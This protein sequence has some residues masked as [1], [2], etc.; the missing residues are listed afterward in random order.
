MAEYVL[1]EMVEK[2]GIAQEFEIASAATSTEE[3][4]MPAYPPAKKKL[5]E[6]GISCEGH[7]AHRMTADEYDYY[8]MVICMDNNNIRSL[9]RRLGEDTDGKYSLM[10]D[11]TDR[12]GYEVADPWYTGNF[13]A[14]WRDVTDG[15][16]GLLKHLGYDE[17]NKQMD[18][19]AFCKDAVFCI[20]KPHVRRGVP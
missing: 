12:A 7:R 15:C 5:A 2:R 18:K 20:R 19:T 1:K 3:I 10:L 9:E 4:G 13:D 11:Y 8:D 16:E 17:Q 14:T 6:N